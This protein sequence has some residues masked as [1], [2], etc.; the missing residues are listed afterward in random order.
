MLA[1]NRRDELLEGKQYKEAEARHREAIA[2]DVGYAPAVNDLG[3]ALAGAGD[4]A[5]GMQAYEQAARLWQQQGSA[6]A[7]FALQNWG[8]LLLDGK[9]YKEAEARY[10]EA[11][12]QDPGYASAVSRLGWALAGAGDTAGAMQAYEQAAKLWQQQGSADAKL[13]LQNWGSLLLDG[14]QYKEAE[15]R[16]REAIAQD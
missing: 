6:D 7:K 4:T 2:H 15:A 16:L 10:R 9:Q 14:K 3:R 11:I 13:A 8:S 1:T 12:A 5:A